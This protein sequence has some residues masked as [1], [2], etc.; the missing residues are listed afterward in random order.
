MNR[1]VINGAL[2]GSGGSENRS[3]ISSSV[4]AIAS[5]ISELS[6]SAMLEASVIAQATTASATH[7]VMQFASEVTARAITVSDYVATGV[8]QLAASVVAAATAI[9]NASAWFKFSASV[10][11]VATTASSIL[12]A[13]GT[14]FT[15][16]VIAKATASASLLGYA[17]LGSVV[18]ASATAIATLRRGAWA[19]SSVFARAT[20]TSK[21][22][23]AATASD[24]R[25]MI[26]PEEARAM[27]LPE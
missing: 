1:T 25:L 19:V 15:S 12:A 3:F 27:E 20:S 21:I 18:S 7:A 22:Q 9:S 5:S 11:A 13:A 10:S 24:D 26:L 8:K 4:Y 6:R 14:F 2:L 23:E 16:A 17:L